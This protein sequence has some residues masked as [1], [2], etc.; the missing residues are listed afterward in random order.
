MST[1][2]ISCVGV[3][4]KFLRGEHHDSLRSVISSMARS[5][6]GRK[7]PAD[8]NNRAFWAVRD[9]TFEVEPGQALGIIGHNGA[10]K[11]TLL[12]LLTRVIRPT[13]GSI[14]VRGRQGALIEVSAGFHPDLTGRENV[15]LQGAIMGMPSA[16]IARKFDQ[17]VEF[18][19]VADFIDTP[20]KRYSNGMNARLGFA[21]AAHLDPDVLIVDEVLSVGDLEFQQKAFGRIK[22]MVTSGIPVVVVSHQLDRVSELCT[23]GILLDHGVVTHQGTPADCIAAYLNPS[24]EGFVTTVDSPAVIDRISLDSDG[25]VTSGGLIRVR[26]EGSVGNGGIPDH[27]DPVV[28]LI[29]NAA[30]GALVSAIGSSGSKLSFSEGA[31]VLDAALQMNVP[32]GLYIIQAMVVN[33]RTERALGTGPSIVLQV[34][35]GMMFAGPIQLNG[36]MSLASL[37]G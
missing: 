25:D 30:T 36:R 2:G 34:G 20:V 1:P 4:K 31:F 9:V 27:V 26:V 7:A 33:R 23:H 35:E 10:G 3:S 11:S 29:R 18:S 37:V 5:I 14:Q 16:D 13:L 15:A 24:Q 21:I 22:D 32:R 17:I 8:P 6:V 28:L 12:K 19:G